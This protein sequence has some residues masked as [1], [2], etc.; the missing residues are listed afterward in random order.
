MRGASLAF[1]ALL[2]SFVALTSPAGAQA[3]VSFDVT[4]EPTRATVGD[5]LTLTIIAH[6]PPEVPL[7]VPTSPGEFDPLD[8]IELRPAESRDV[9]GGLQE[10]RFVYVVAAFRTGEMQPPRLHVAALGEQNVATTLQPP[11]VFIESVLPDAA[12]PDLRDLK[13]PLQATSDGTGT[14]VV[15]ALLMA[16]FLGLSVLT[17]ALARVPTLRTPPPFVAPAEPAEPAEQAARRELNAIAAADHLDQGELSE[18]Y[19]RIAACLRRYLTE[20]YD[21]P[22]VAMT[23]QE[24]EARLEGL[25]VDRW[26][27]RLAVNLLDQCQAVQFAGYEPA[28]DRA[29]SDLS[30][31]YEVV[32]LTSA[33]EASARP[34]EEAPTRS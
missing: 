1:V 11:I 7:E 24:L 2:A 34:D 8:L 20:R 32:A 5:H 6:H 21:V 12:P 23:P 30:A 14:W 13:E 9:A 19:R 33:P 17:M 18:H 3:P 25:E 4:L 28:R 31:A 27:V 22:A 10:T 29:E 15:G 16:G 26:P